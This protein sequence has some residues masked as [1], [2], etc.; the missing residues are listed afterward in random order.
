[1]P[2]RFRVVNSMTVFDS[3]ASFLSGTAFP[4]GSEP[5][6]RRQAVVEDAS[7]PA[8]GEM[9]ENQLTGARHFLAVNHKV[10]QLSKLG[11]P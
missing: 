4:F 11:F 9:W 8:P 6:G 2:P 5:Q 7:G 10:V 1:M 3:A